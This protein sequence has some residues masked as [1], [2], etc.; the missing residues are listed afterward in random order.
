MCLHTKTAVGIGM[1]SLLG[2][3]IALLN[4]PITA[5][6]SLEQQQGLRGNESF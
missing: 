4:S 5:P 1:E 6:L 3:W 2:C